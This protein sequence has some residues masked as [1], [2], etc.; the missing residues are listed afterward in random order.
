MP[1]ESPNDIARRSLVTYHGAVEP[2]GHLDAY[3]DISGDLWLLHGTGDGVILP[4][5]TIPQLIE[6]LRAF[7]GAQDGCEDA[8]D[9]GES[10]EEFCHECGASLCE[11][12]EDWCGSDANED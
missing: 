9:T 10:P 1:Q 4:A 2:P 11:E 6:F 5:D 8:P 12:H 7:I 3:T